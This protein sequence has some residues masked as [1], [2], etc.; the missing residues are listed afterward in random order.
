MVMSGDQN[1]ACISRYVSF[2]SH[3]KNY[4]VNRQLTHKNMFLSNRD[5]I[6]RYSE[7]LALNLLRGIL[8]ITTFKRLG[9][10]LSYCWK[11]G[12]CSYVQKRFGISTT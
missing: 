2:I 7:S 1:A 6:G 8:C 4:N 10:S 3:A 11:D 12:D 5:M 9:I